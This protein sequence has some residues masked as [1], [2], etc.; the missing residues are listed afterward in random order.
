MQ[1]TQIMNE[2]FRKL[3]EKATG[4]SQYII[5]IVLDIRGFTPFCQIADSLDVA[6]YIKKIYMKIIDDYF[7]D[8]SF[9]KPA[10]D[11]LLITIRSPMKKRLY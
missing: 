8:A 3:L 10:G 5:V 2:G 11:G 6:T 1:V 7:P 9:Y 4:K